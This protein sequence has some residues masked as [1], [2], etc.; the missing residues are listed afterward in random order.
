ME[1]VV[2]TGIGAVTSLGADVDTMWS[3][4]LSCE[5]G[6]KPI[7]RLDIPPEDVYLSAEVT[8]FDVAPFLTKPKLCKYLNRQSTFMLSAAHQAM[9]SSG[10]LAAKA[11]SGLRSALIIGA[12]ACLADEYRDIPNDKRRPTWYLDTFPNVITSI[13]SINFGLDGHYNTLLNAC[14]SGTKAIIDGANLIRAGICDFALVGSTDSKITRE[15]LQGFKALNVL[16]RAKDPESAMRPFDKNRDGTVIGEGAGALLLESATA[17]LVRGA[18]IYGYVSGG[19]YAMDG[20][21]LVEPAQNGHGLK[22]AMKMALDS[23]GLSPSQIGHLNTHGTSTRANDWMESHAIASVFKENLENLPITASKSLL[24]HTTAAS[25]TLEAIV[26]LKSLADQMVHP[27]ANFTQIKDVAP[28]DYVYKVARPQ[29]FEYA[30]SNSIG[31]G[32]FNAS[33]ILRRADAV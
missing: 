8:E 16:S 33:L 23:A 26:T 4:L 17:A 21:S 27:I 3:R 2:I 24:G 25:G 22:K 13:I 1:D 18:K 19:G 6:I 10:L 14:A 12:G 9:A 15:H 5:S 11:R 28:L 29:R 32:G 31:I 20:A 30:L 7:T